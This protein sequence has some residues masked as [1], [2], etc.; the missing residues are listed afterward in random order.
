[1]VK[2]VGGP[3]PGG[4]YTSPAAIER[5]KRNLERYR[6]VGFLEDE[7]SVVES[8]EEQFSIRLQ[9]G[10]RNESPVSQEFR[11]SQVTPQI[12]EEIRAVCR[13]DIELYE[14]AQGLVAGGR[15]SAATAAG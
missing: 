3:R 8:F 12:E 7:A 14:Y 6:V 13:P 15:R 5:A 9:L 2:Y 10:R 11:E 1:M 4:D